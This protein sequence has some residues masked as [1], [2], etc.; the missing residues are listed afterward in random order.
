MSLQIKICIQK[1]IKNLKKDLENQNLNNSISSFL[2]LVLRINYSNID[3][4]IN[5]PLFVN[6]IKKRI[7]AKNKI[8]ILGGSVAKTIPK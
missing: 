3:S 8:L 4:F 7:F 2:V 5:E 1:N 6:D